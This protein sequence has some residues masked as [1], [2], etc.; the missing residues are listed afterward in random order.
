MSDIQLNE[1]FVLK[2]TNQFVNKQQIFRQKS[3]IPARQNQLKSLEE[4]TTIMTKIDT[5][6]NQI[7]QFGE[8]VTQDIESNCKEFV[9]LDEN[10]LTNL[11][12]MG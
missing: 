4:I 2:S 5:Q 10:V 7:Q 3:S 11:E 8:S 12:V 9:N 6:M 1:N